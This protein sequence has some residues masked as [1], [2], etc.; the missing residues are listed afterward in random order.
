[1]EIQMSV[2]R[3]ITQIDWQLLNKQRLILAEL[4]MS[5]VVTSQQEDALSGVVNLLDEMCDAKG[6]T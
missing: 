4:M 6:V 2:D 1:M 5:A 3:I